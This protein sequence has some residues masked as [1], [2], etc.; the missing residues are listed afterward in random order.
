[1]TLGMVFFLLL[2]LQ[3]ASWYTWTISEHAQNKL[4]ICLN[5]YY[6][7]DFLFARFPAYHSFYVFSSVFDRLHFW[8]F[9]D[10]YAVG[11]CS[12]NMPDF[13]GKMLVKAG[14]VVNQVI[15]R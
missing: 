8:L 12:E 5:S 14:A 4:G 13:R 10:S 9:L 6:W 2:F 15:R 1:M 3:F 11:V 7:P